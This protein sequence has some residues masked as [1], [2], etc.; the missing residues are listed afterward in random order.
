MLGYDET[1]FVWIKAVHVLASVLWVGGAIFIQIYVTRLQRAQESSRLGAFAKDVES[2]GQRV[3]LPASVL[4]LLAGIA[5][6]WYS[7]AFEVADLWVILGLLGIANTIVI[8]ALFL[9]PE[10][11][12]V[13]RLAE[14]SGPEDPEV[15]RRT[16]RLFTISR[17]DLSVLILVIVVMVTKPTL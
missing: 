13:A 16:A 4:V 6:V 1:V 11:G 10:A 14:G 17:I 9:G 2:I 15:V 8:G 3:F 7:P 5:M 12:K